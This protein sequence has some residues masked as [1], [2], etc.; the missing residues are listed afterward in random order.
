[1][2]IW[3]DGWQLEYKQRFLR[4][5]PKHF[6]F[7]LRKDLPYLESVFSGIWQNDYI[8][9]EVY[10]AEVGVARCLEVLW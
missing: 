2:Q 7:F 10:H 5:Y 8:C 1:M 9:R 3:L 4:L 6:C